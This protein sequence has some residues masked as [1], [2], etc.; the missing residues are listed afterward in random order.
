MAGK[1]ALTNCCRIF[2]VNTRNIS[3]IVTQ[4]RWS[5]YNPHYLEPTIDK[6]ELK[7]PLEEQDPRRFQPIKAIRSE[8]TVA[9]GYDF[10][11][12][13]FINIMMKQGN[14]RLSREIFEKCLENIKRIQ[15]QK[16][17]KSE[18][19]ERSSIEL[20]PMNIFHQAI[21]NCRPLLKLTRINKGGVAYQVPVPMTEKNSTFRAMKWMIE[22]AKAKDANTR[23]Y[24]QLAHE[25]INAANNTGKSIKKKQELHKQCESNKAYAHFR[26]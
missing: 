23:M 20:N 7:K 1:A 16:Y 15:L 10:Q 21:E 26:W 5:Q 22:S 3:P 13:K 2:H 18:E 9:L 6:T 19:N 24:D 8:Q 4:V 14:K 12:E 17:H 25:L 11:R